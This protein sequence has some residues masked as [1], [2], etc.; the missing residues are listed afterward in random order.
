MQHCYLICWI[1]NLT[2][3][4]LAYNFSYRIIKIKNAYEKKGYIRETIKLT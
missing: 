1:S 3:S 4:D 2:A